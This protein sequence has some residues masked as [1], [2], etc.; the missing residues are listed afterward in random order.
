MAESKSETSLTTKEIRIQV[1]VDGN[2]IPREIRWAADDTATLDETDSRAM[3]LSLWDSRTK[4]TF[5][6]D[7]WTHKMTVDEMKIFFHQTLTSMADS[8]ERATKDERITGDM[9]DFCDYFAER[10][11]IKEKP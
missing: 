10:M 5:K 2:H 1:D 8:L 4:D 7:L 9:R 6:L 11:D 3:F